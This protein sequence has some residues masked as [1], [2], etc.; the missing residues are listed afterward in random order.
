MGISGPLVV[1][2]RVTVRV[3]LFVFVQQTSEK[4]DGAHI[5]FL[6]LTAPSILSSFTSF[7]ASHRHLSAHAQGKHKRKQQQ[8]ADNTTLI[9]IHLQP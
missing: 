8:T 1:A 9:T 4:R 5:T 2:F 6:S 3:T 7:R